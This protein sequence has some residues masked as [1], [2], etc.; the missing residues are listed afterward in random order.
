MSGI[1][2]HMQNYQSKF[3]QFYIIYYMHCD[4]IV[5]DQTNQMHKLMF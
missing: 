3:N 2:W 4:V 1:F 5:T